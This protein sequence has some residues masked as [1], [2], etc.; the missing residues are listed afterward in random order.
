METV[1]GILFVLSLFGN[2]GQANKIADQGETIDEQAETIEMLTQVNES[3]IDAAREAANIARSNEDVV[4]DLNQDL[5]VC[6]EKLRSFEAS[7]EIFERR[8]QDDDR[9]IEKLENI[10][11]DSDLDSCR[12]PDRVVYEITRNY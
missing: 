6:A 11:N 5:N 12:V 8:R 9:A 7:R 10:I 4:N 1:I 2:W 3:N